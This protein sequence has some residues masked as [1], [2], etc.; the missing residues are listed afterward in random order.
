MEWKKLCKEELF[1]KN[2]FSSYQNYLI[3]LPLLNM[4][5]ILYSKFLQHLET[6]SLYNIFILVAKLLSWLVI[7]IFLI[8]THWTIENIAIA[9]KWYDFAI[10]KIIISFIIVFYRK[11]ILWV[12]KN[13]IEE[14]RPA[15]ECSLYQGIPII[16][17][18]DY[19][20]TSKSFSRNEFCEQF[21]VSRK[22]F[23]DMANWLDKIGV[24]VRG[25]N[26][27]RVLSEEFSRTDISSIITRASDNWEIR[28]LI[29]KTENWFTHSPTFRTMSIAEFRTS[30]S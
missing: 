23:D 3:F 24:F 12:A 18:V 20:F 10:I 17:L 8:N 22:V 7:C 1:Q 25:A 19:L 11:S 6:L 28:H 27:S 26:N 4:I 30:A 14:F 16:E 21:A 13:I 29:R 9:L 2:N 5:S 15:P